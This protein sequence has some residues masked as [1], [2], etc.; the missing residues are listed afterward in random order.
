MGRGWVSS[1]EANLNSGCPVKMEF[2]TNNEI[3][4]VVLVYTQ[5]CMEHITCNTWEICILKMHPSFI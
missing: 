2:H 4:F 3:L 5:Y 1:S